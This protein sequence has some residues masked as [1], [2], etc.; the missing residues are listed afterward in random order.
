MIKLIFAAFVLCEGLALAAP[1]KYSS[2]DKKTR[3]PAYQQERRELAQR[4]IILDEQ[5]TRF[6]ILAESGLTGFGS[7]MGLVGGYFFMPGQMI[8]ASFGK[9]GHLIRELDTITYG[10]RL[11]SF[12]GRYFSSTAGLSR[13]SFTFATDETYTDILVADTPRKW[14]YDAEADRTVLELGIG[15]RWTIGR[16]TFGCDWV[17]VLVPLQKGKISAKTVGTAENLQ[18]AKDASSDMEKFLDDTDLKLVHF[19]LGITF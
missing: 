4:D 13:Q 12:W 15:N 11:R 16:F 1:K 14:S 18:D 6:L 19:H 2:V 10:V 5:Y 3:V 8:E 9:G 17:G 7:N